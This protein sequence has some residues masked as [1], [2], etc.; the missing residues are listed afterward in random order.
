MT[1]KRKSKKPTPT[2]VL[3]KKLI[4]IGMS[5]GDVEPGWETKPLPM[6]WDDFKD[7][8]R[9][10]VAEL[11]SLPQ[12]CPVRRCRRSRRCKG[13]EA[14]CLTHHRQKAAERINLMMGFHVADIFDE[15]QDDGT[16]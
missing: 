7:W 11:V 13:E 12:I 5:G 6:T 3:I 2:G 15:E 1:K 9:R 8:R 10:T 4:R 16:W 14:L